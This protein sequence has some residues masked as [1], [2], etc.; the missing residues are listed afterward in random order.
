MVVFYGLSAAIMVTTYFKGALL[1]QRYQQANIPDGYM[2]RCAERAGAYVQALQ[3]NEWQKVWPL[4]SLK[5]QKKL[6]TQFS[7]KNVEW[8]FR[9]Q[10][11]GKDRSALSARLRGYYF[12]GRKVVRDPQV[13][14][15]EVEFI[16]EIGNT[17]SFRLIEQKGMPH[18]ETLPPDL[19]W[20]ELEPDVE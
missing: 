20:I 17:V 15:V 13:V 9:T 4:L 8:Y 5:A 7:G 2:E 16:N 3:K 19:E 11:L 18:I 12:L 14:I 10:Y 6:A 1:S